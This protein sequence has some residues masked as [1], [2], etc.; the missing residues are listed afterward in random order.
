M[1]REVIYSDGEVTVIDENG[2]Q[3]QV[4]YSDNVCDILVQGNMIEIMELELQQLEKESESC[5]K[6]NE[7]GYTPIIFDRGFKLQRYSIYRHFVN[8][9]KGV[10]SELEYLKDRI[11]VEKDILGKLRQDRDK[12]NQ[13]K[14][15]SVTDDL[16]DLQKLKVLRRALNL[17]YHLGYNSEKYSK[18]YTLGRL[19]NL[20][21]SQNFSED[22]ILHANIYFREKKPTLVKRKKK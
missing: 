1:N 5:R 22:D 15:F 21:R 3:R 7:R 2:Q 8:Q 14:N 6:I 4:E 18:Y 20:L 11:A 13:F 10:N 19:E 9:E 12:Q 16:V 17:H